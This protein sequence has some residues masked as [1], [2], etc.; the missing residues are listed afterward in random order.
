MSDGDN[1]GKTDAQN[2]EQLKQLQDEVEKFKKQAE[3]AEKKFQEHSAEVGEARKKL[4]QAE[5][6]TKELKDRLAEIE[7]NKGEPP[8]KEDKKEATATEIAATLKAEQRKVAEKMFDGLTKEEKERY[9]DD[10][11][12]RK[13]FLLQVTELKPIPNSPWIEPE[14]KKEA[15]ETP[16]AHKKRIKELFDATVKQA[17]AAPVGSAGGELASRATQLGEAQDEK[18]NERLRGILGRNSRA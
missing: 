18:S 7:K 4:E 5:K 12:F 3:H 13:D 16:E 17:K 9:R 11:S 10:E 6:E 8:K 14:T 15:K 2:V 1:T